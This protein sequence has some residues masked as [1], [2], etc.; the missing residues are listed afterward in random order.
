M[1]SWTGVDEKEFYYD[2]AVK[3]HKQFT[4]LFRGRFLP[5][6]GVLT[7]IEAAKR[8]EQSGIQFHIIGN[9]FMYREVAALMGKLEPQNIMMTPATLPVNELRKKMLACHLS[10]GQLADHPRLLR[11]LPCKLFES[12]ALRLPYL[13][14]RNPGALELLVE[15][16]TC[17]AVKPGDSTDLAEKILLIKNNPDLL[18]K[19]ARQ[20]FQLYKTKL[21]S[22]QLALD[23][24]SNCFPR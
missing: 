23:V 12:I 20:G 11:T 6:S 13:T 7:V 2:T 15:N 3:K 24:L 18:E 14:A 19:V 16:E 4:V 1:R 22:K 21:T 8:L 5:E 10:L 17:F 9:G